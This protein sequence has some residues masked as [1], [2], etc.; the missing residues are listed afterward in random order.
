LM[1]LSVWLNDFE[2]YRTE[3]EYRSYLI[4]KVFSFRFMCYFAT[5]YYYAFLSVGSD[6]AIENGI[7]RVGTSVFVYTTV[8]HWWQLAVHVYFPIV[9]RK[10]RMNHRRKRLGCELRDV[11]LEEEEI[12]RLAANEAAED[13]ER[14]RLGNVSDP[15]EAEISRLAGS[16]L[17]KRQAADD[18]K[19]RHIRTINKRLLLEQAQD[20][21]WL[22]VMLPQHDSF[23]EYISAVVQFTFVS[24]FSVVFP[25]TPLICLFN[26]LLSMRLDAYKLCKGRRRPLSEKTGGIGIWE[27]LL[28]IVAVI[29][30]LT[31]CWLVGFTTQQFRWIGDKIGDIGLFAIVVGWEH[32]MLLV[33]YVMDT[34]VSPLP[35]SVR[36]DILRE[37]F[38][39][40]QQRNS[41]LQDRRSQHHREGD[42]YPDNGN[43]D[44]NRPEGAASPDRHV[45][46]MR[47]IPFKEREIDVRTPLVALQTIAS[48]DADSDDSNSIDSPPPI[49]ASLTPPLHPHSDRRL[50]SA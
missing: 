50:F 27:H 19:K 33:K 30:V 49:P 9:I 45:H 43:H 21:I 4:I 12:A 17:T 15:K 42:S 25:L 18:L 35:N 41:N 32:I 38:Q 26:Y 31:N 1:K 28:H 40:D 11:A 8:A 3:S 16:D 34:T 7:F 36:D 29:S 44:T 20:G 14:L 48:H 2:N 46:G 5:L 24:C 6:E 23:P 22:E 37:Q 47:A 10:F 13:L 39:S